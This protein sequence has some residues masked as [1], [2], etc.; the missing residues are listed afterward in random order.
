MNLVGSAAIGKKKF[1]D[2]FRGQS[3]REAPNNTITA[4]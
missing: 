4:T 2:N 3:F 1:R